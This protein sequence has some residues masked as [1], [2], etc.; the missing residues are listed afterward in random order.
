MKLSRRFQIAAI[1]ALCLLAV[2][3]AVFVRHQVQLR[4]LQ[5]SLQAE[6]QTAMDAGNPAEAV[7]KLQQY[8]SLVPQDHEARKQLARAMLSAESLPDHRARA[9]FLY[10]RLHEFAPKDVE[11]LTVLVQQTMTSSES[12]RTVNDETGAINTHAGQAESYLKKLVALT[13]TEAR[14]CLELA[15]FYVRRND[16][17]R[18]TAAFAQATEREP[19]TL[20]V[21]LARAHFLQ[22]VADDAP[23]ASAVLETLLANTQS[24]TRALLAVA[25]FH[26]EF[27]NPAAARTAIEQAL[28]QDPVSVPALRLAAD[29]TLDRACG[30]TSRVVTSQDSD[31]IVRLQAR[32]EWA[33]KHHA[34]ASN[35]TATSVM[36]AELVGIRSRLLW[37][38]GQH[39][40]ALQALKS[41]SERFPNNQTLHVGYLQM[42]LDG[43]HTSHAAG[44]LARDDRKDD[45]NA[46]LL[47]LRGRLAV[48]QGRPT[49]ARTL[50]LAALAD[51]RTR[52]ESLRELTQDAR[53]NLR[54]Q[55]AD[56]WLELV[57][58]FQEF[59]RDDL[60][61]NAL[62]QALAVCPA[63]VRARVALIERL[64]RRHEYAA[65]LPHC[66]FLQHVSGA[67]ILQG[68]LLICRQLQLPPPGQDW[69]TA[70]EL[71]AQVQAD[72]H[73]TAAAILLSVQ[74][75]IAQGRL[76]TAI[77]TAEAVFEKSTADESSARLRESLGRVF[78]RTMHDARTAEAS[79][80]EVRAWLTGHGLSVTSPAAERVASLEATSNT[81][82]SA[83]RGLLQK[84]DAVAAGLSGDQQREFWRILV[85]R[86][87][88]NSELTAAVWQRIA[89][90][91]PRDPESRCR[92]LEHAFNSGDIATAERQHHELTEIDG[93]QGDFALY[94]RAVCLLMRARSAEAPEFGQAED[95][96]L[97]VERRAA[98]WGRVLHLLGVIAEQRQQWIQA[99]VYYQRAIEQSTEIGGLVARRIQMLNNAERFADVEPWLH[100]LA[101]RTRDESA[102]AALWRIAGNT[103]GALQRH[104]EAVL[105]AQRAVALEPQHVQG[106]LQLASALAA[107]GR[108]ESAWDAWRIVLQLGGE[109]PDVVL[110]AMK[111]L[112]DRGQSAQAEQL[113]TSTLA[114]RKNQAHATSADKAATALLA[115]DGATLLGRWEDALVVCQAKLRESPNDVNLRVRWARLQR[116][117]GDL[118]GAV[119]TLQ[120]LLEQDDAARASGSRLLDALTRQQAEEWLVIMLTDRGE[121]ADQQ[122]ALELIDRQRYSLDNRSRQLRARALVYASRG[123]PEDL[124]LAKSLFA[125]LAEAQQL[126]PGDRLIYARLLEK[127]CDWEQAGAQYLQLVANDARFERDYWMFVR[128][129]QRTGLWDVA[130]ARIQKWLNSARAGLLPTL[131]HADQ[132][133][134]RGNTASAIHLVQQRLVDPMKAWTDDDRQSAAVTVADWGSRARQDG[135]LTAAADCRAL[136]E[137]LAESITEPRLREPTIVQLLCLHDDVAAAIRHCRR[138]VNTTDA[139]VTAAAMSAAAHSSGLTRETLREFADQ[140]RR[141]EQTGKGA[142][143]PELLLAIASLEGR[144]GR[145][146]SAAE[147]LRRVIRR[148]RQ[149][150]SALNNL[151]WLLSRSQNLATDNTTANGDANGTSLVTRRLATDRSD[152]PQ[153]R[154]A[155]RLV[156]QALLLEPALPQL[157]DTRGCVRLAAGDFRGAIRD[158][159]QALLHEPHAVGYVHLAEAYASAG[160]TSSARAALADARRLGLQAESL[161]PLEARHYQRLL[162]TLAE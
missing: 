46:S 75:D 139:A 6:A 123:T 144:L 90:L 13:P 134:A 48:V 155:R 33:I 15:R 85:K 42:L 64:S 51:N 9:L 71:I 127:T 69:S 112:V 53:R 154:E 59:G 125:S 135:D 12:T 19:Q 119:N 41:A 27:L 68:Q 120:N 124:T 96:L 140:L 43:N 145:L 105:W 50:L 161:H 5:R 29:V 45:E 76:S 60:I 101:V 138:L 3:V 21:W 79:Q 157:L 159:E 28:Q 86:L 1:A 121:A 115:A 30:M 128:R 80:R 126:S 8:L 93:E 34:A 2:A 91:E 158:F 89:T 74:R 122:L 142:T 151:A 56:I 103:A 113:L 114:R 95:L 117:N 47:F 55:Q 11:V 23:A 110:A 24:S 111:F 32:V 37:A 130:D 84:H 31:A 129:L 132:L 22:T 141:L 102:Q 150:V 106:Q 49:Q 107:A 16:L 67:D 72:P 143:A 7:I 25:R 57:R 109:Q 149:Q 40:A 97:T 118:D 94:A 98:G 63:C 99:A 92:L 104:R 39:T 44:I 153:L 148:D 133:A 73:R 87:P 82:P 36:D 136:A 52:L 116:M 17:T 10:R 38:R 58:C 162:I 83:Q 147:A 88:R 62:Q 152:A 156:E 78:L 108:H 35:T 18:A 54:R 26:E 131:A 14:W 66:R 146:D 20:D 160:R 81:S 137:S 100:D 4:N 61:D 65:A 77:A 70:D